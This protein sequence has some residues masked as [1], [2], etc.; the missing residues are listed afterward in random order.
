MKLAKMSINLGYVVDLD[1]EEMVNY[2]KECLYDDIMQL[3]KYNEVADLV[4]H[5]ECVESPD[6]TEDDIPEFLIEYVR[7][8]NEEE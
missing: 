7:E 1:N 5:C 2:A 4:E 6:L 3:V 8:F